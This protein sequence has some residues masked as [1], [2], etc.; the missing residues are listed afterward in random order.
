MQDLWDPSQ[1]RK[2][3]P[4][5]QFLHQNH[6]DPHRIMSY[7]SKRIPYRELLRHDNKSSSL[8]ISF[9]SYI[10]LFLNKCIEY[11]HKFLSEL[12]CS[13]WTMLPGPHKWEPNEINKRAKLFRD[14]WER[15][16][17]VNGISDATQRLT[18]RVQDIGPPL[19]QNEIDDNS[20]DTKV[21]IKSAYVPVCSIT[22]CFRRTL[23]PYAEMTLKDI[24]GG[25]FDFL[26]EL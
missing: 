21:F 19:V 10:L 14:W 1:R 8:S 6:K 20:N 3:R 12:F 13:K 18:F 16:L 15:C 23:I 24:C 5:H 17:K 2:W 4:Q 25:S 9:S 22:E 11:V 26:C 7:N